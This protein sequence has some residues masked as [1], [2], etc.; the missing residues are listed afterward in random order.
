MR[1]IP[2]G[3]PASRTAIRSLSELPLSIEAAAEAGY[4]IRLEAD[5]CAEIRKPAWR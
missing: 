5:G 1:T 2:D 3:G 4:R